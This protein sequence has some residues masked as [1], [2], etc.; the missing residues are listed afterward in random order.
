MLKKCNYVFKIFTYAD[1]SQ[2]G[3]DISPDEGY[4]KHVDVAQMDGRRLRTR[5]ETIY[6]HIGAIYRP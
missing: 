3:A 1:I 5:A 6:R 2:L 4:G